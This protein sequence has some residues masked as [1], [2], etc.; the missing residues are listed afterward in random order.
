MKCKDDGRDDATLAD[1]QVSI[2]SEDYMALL[3]ECRPSSSSQASQLC[4]TVCRPTS[5]EVERDRVPPLAADE[6]VRS[7]ATPADSLHA[8]QLPTRWQTDLPCDGQASRGIH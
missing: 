5:A 7:H 1:K 3:L 8:L 2:G 4:D 6:R